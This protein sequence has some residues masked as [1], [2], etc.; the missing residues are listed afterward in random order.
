[1]QLRVSQLLIVWNSLTHFK[2]FSNDISLQIYI[3]VDNIILYV[4]LLNIV[5]YG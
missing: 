2:T 3:M 5:L 1:M 4:L